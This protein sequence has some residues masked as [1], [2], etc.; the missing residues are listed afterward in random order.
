L[1]GIGSWRKG[2]AYFCHSFV[3]PQDEAALLHDPEMLKAVTDINKQVTA[4]A[5]VLNSADTKDYVTVGSS[6]KD[7][8]VDVLTK[9]YKNANYIFSVGMRPGFTTATFNVKSGST[10]EVIGEGRKLKITDGK[11]SDEFV[12]YGVHLYKIL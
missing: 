8:F 4:L 12:P 2:Y 10:V 7:V 1:D 3:A 11:F 9:N 6:N 5:P